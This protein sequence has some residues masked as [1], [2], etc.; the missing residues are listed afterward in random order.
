MEHND[1]VIRT[2]LLNKTG[3]SRY[4][5]RGSWITFPSGSYLS[6]VDWVLLPRHYATRLMVHVL[7]GAR[8]GVLALSW[9]ST[10]RPRCSVSKPGIH[11]SVGLSPAARQRGGDSSTAVT[12]PAQSRPGPARPPQCGRDNAHVS[13]IPRGL[14]RRDC[15]GSSMKGPALW[16]N[17]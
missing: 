17:H 9:W 14:R 13:A 8:G 1:P 7:W 10:L 11:Y 4:K 5:G 2:S 12:G 3:T 15:G 16:I 6:K